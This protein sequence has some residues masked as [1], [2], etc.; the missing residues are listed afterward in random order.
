MSGRQSRNSPFHAARGRV[1]TKPFEK[2][3]AAFWPGWA[4]LSRRSDPVQA[5]LA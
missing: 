3:A 1:H 4:E 5:M 2:P